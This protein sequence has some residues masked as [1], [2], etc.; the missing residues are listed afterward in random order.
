MKEVVLHGRKGKSGGG[1][2]KRGCD[3]QCQVHGVHEHTCQVQFLWAFG[4]TSVFVHE[5]LECTVVSFA[6]IEA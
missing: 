6:S 4:D 2:S 3:V 1:E 5:V